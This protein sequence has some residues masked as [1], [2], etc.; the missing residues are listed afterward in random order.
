MEAL[1]GLAG[2]N[3]HGE[4]VMADTVN[5]HC[6]QKDLADILLTFVEVDV[7]VQ[8]HPLADI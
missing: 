5:M 7:V 6:M 2:I 8:A 4:W 3:V 1:T